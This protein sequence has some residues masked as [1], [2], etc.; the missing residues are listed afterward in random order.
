MP[1]SYLMDF[2]GLVTA[3]GLVDAEN[4]LFAEF[5]CDSYTHADRAVRE[6]A[7]L[8]FFD[9]KETMRTASPYE[10]K[11][12][13]YLAASRAISRDQRHRNLPKV[14]FFFAIGTH[15]PWILQEVDAWTGAV[16]PIQLYDTHGWDEVW[17]AAGLLAERRALE[18]TL[19]AKRSVERARR[20]GDAR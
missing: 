15:A 17:T 3:D 9:R 18:Q 10:V 19:L 5:V 16:G 6:I 1:S 13:V 7:F 20:N 2:D 4:R 8:A 14:R 11:T 12:A